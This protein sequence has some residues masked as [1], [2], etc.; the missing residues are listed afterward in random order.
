MT[1]TTFTMST[2]L[3]LNGNYV[4]CVKANYK[5]E[6]KAMVVFFDKDYKVL[7]AQ[8]GELWFEPLPLT[9]SKFK[10][11]VSL[12]MTFARWWAQNE[13]ELF[14]NTHPD[15]RDYN[16]IWGVNHIIDFNNDEDLIALY[17]YRMLEEARMEEKYLREEAIREEWLKYPRI[18]K[19]LSRE[20]PIEFDPRDGAVA[21]AYTHQFGVSF[22]V[23]SF[24]EEG[25]KY[26]IMYFN[27][28]SEVPSDIPIYRGWLEKPRNYDSIIKPN[29]NASYYYDIYSGYD[30]CGGS[31][32]MLSF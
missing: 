6:E 14:E 32:S 23:L 24:D 28:R 9:D 19:P 8:E 12:V 25:Y 10:L 5:T 22:I 13:K 2:G 18:N 16:S 30:S 31:S 29:E 1:K 21:I 26:E 27:Y 17:E 7:A 4:V 20:L 3:T 15:E 11:S